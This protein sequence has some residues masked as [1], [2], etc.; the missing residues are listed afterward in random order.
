M[1]TTTFPGRH[2]LAARGVVLA[3]DGGCIKLW[4]EIDEDPAAPPVLLLCASPGAGDWTAPEGGRRF[5]ALVH[6]TAGTACRHPEV[7]ATRLAWRPEALEA[8]QQ[9]CAEWF[10]T[11]QGAWGGPSLPEANRYNAFLADRFGPIV[12]ADTT[13]GALAEGWYPVDPT[14]RALARLTSEAL[15]DDLNDLVV[16]DSEVMRFAGSVGRWTVVIAGPNSD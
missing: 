6:Q 2:G 3:P 16:F 5:E 10:E 1:D 9:V 13:Y 14:P 12:N 7:V 15:P 8:A 4:D 11:N